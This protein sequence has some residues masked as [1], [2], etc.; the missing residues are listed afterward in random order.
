MK[1]TGPMEWSPIGPV[2]E[3]R[4]DLYRPCA[5]SQIAFICAMS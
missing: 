3:Q 4:R 2:W 5:A 1:R